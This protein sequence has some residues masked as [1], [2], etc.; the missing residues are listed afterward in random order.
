MN[1]R[2][3]QILDQITALEAEL[4]KIL[5]ESETKLSYQIKNSRIVFE[6]NLEAAHHRVKLG[7]FRWFMTVRP[8]NY[9]TMPII[10]GMAI[11]L[12]LFDM[13]I[14]LYQ[15]S[16]FPIYRISRVKRA[17]Y[18]V[19]DHQHLAYLNII[20]KI[21]CVY[22]SY[23]VGLLGYAQEIIARTEQ[24]FCPIKHATKIL[25]PHS[26]YAQFL[27]YGD[28]THLHEK[29]EALRTELAKTSD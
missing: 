19:I 13:C 15:L 7:L 10:Y 24:Y 17:G 6:K 12:I 4:Q 26:H 22:C 14:S 23:G 3:R 1:P 8:Q 16:C 9:L 28:A 21:H 2:T 25:S 18:F 11:P 27:T 5:L 20:E 29:M